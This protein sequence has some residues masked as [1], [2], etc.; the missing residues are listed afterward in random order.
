MN[1][2]TPFQISLKCDPEWAVE[3]RERFQAIR[4]A[5]HMN[6]KHWNMIDVEGSVP[7]KEILNMIDH[8]YNLVVNKFTK[9]ENSEYNKLC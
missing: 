2:E 8:S 6:N 5:Y 7:L 9:K 4:P 3:L 1:F